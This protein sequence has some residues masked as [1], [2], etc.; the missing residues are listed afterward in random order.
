[1]GCAMAVSVIVSNLNGMKFLPRL[2]E[3]LRAQRGV[4]A[5]LVGVDR[6]SHDGSAEYLAAQ[7]DVTV[8]PRPPETRLGSGHAARGRPA[9]HEHLFF[10]TEDMWFDPDCLRLLEEGIDLDAGVAAADPWQWTYDGEQLIHAGTRFRRVAWTPLCA[11][12]FRCYSFTEPV[13]SGAV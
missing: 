12:P 1:R 4:T 8:V 13:A 10:C 5:Q 11:Y 6:L 3:T 7:P 9:R 2:L